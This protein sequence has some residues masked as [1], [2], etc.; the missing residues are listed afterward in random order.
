MKLLAFHIEFINFNMNEWIILMN[1]TQVSVSTANTMDVMSKTSDCSWPVRDPMDII[2]GWTLCNWGSVLHQLAFER[3]VT[4]KW[5]TEYAC[6]LSIS[7]RRHWRR[8]LCHH[9]LVLS[10]LMGWKSV[11]DTGIICWRHP[12]TCATHN[13]HIECPTLDILK[14]TLK[15]II[16][17]FIRYTYN[18]SALR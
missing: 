10:W 8:R 3:M 9:L 15:L 18:F 16:D 13:R 12:H 11:G 7:F 17:V 14:C 4:C 1:S 5:V 2:R 6:L